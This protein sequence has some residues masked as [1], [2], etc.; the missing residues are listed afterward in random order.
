MQ[1]HVG[2]YYIGHNLVDHNFMGCAFVGG[3]LGVLVTAGSIL[4]SR[5]GL[6]TAPSGAV[7][8]HAGVFVGERVMRGGL[9]WNILGACV[10]AIDGICV[11]CHLSSGSTFGAN[12][13]AT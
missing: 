10:S 2:H 1:A 3:E 13:K 11:P 6:T 4:G 5:A 7:G 12:V 9:V 8:K